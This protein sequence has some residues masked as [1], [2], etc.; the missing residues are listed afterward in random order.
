M[1]G[2][3]AVSTH[4]HS[5]AFNRAKGVSTPPQ[6]PGACPR[7]ILYGDIRL[8]P[9]RAVVDPTRPLGNAV[10]VDRAKLAMLSAI[11]AM[12]SA[13]LAM[14]SDGDTKCKDLCES[15]AYCI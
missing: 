2:A 15:G 8:G 1:S 9:D 12:L 6:W 3:P 11:L 5:Q 14:L 13:K 4:S 10:R 7:C